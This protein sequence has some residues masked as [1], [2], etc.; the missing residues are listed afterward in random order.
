[1]RLVFSGNFMDAL[2]STFALYQQAEKPLYA[3]VNK[4][5]CVLIITDIPGDS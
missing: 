1:A 2:N 3:S 5:Q 4:N